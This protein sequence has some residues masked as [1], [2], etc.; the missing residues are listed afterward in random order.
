MVNIDDVYQKVL[1]FL[2]KEQRGY[3]T[4]QE[5]NLFAEQAQMEI[6]EQY[7]YDLNQYSRIQNS[8]EEFGR[9]LQ[10]INEK[11]SIF[12]TSSAL[13]AGGNIGNA[14]FYRLGTVYVGTD[15][16]EV[17]EV[18]LD[19]VLYMNK[20]PL[21]KPTKNRPVYVRTKHK[22]LTVYPVVSNI[23]F[24]YIKKPSKP[25]WGYFVVGSKALFDSDLSKTTHFELHDSEQT[26][27]VYKILKFAGISTEK[28]DI[29]RAGQIQEQAQ[30]QQEKL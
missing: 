24:N 30:I 25:Q 19:E 27:L 20:S 18:Q 3:L 6:F 16:T 10:N 21:T 4:P 9:V 7:F 2:N 23:R 15:G 29:M 17:E 8:D 12:Q 11:I 1:A 5:F 28:L 13:L 14:D 26:E 22:T